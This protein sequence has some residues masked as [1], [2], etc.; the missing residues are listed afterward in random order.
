MRQFFWLQKYSF[1]SVK[2]EKT[3]SHLVR[4]SLS[5]CKVTNKGVKTQIYRFAQP[6]LHKMEELFA[7]K[8]DEELCASFARLLSIF[9]LSTETFFFLHWYIFLLPHSILRSAVQNNNSALMN[10]HSAVQND[11]SAVWNIK[12]LVENLEI[13]RGDCNFAALSKKNS[14]VATILFI[15]TNNFVHQY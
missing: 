10:N 11:G 5:A 12:F 6:S 7:D 15:Y 14:S 9:P 13:C 1:L 4:I 3:G 8:A 2:A